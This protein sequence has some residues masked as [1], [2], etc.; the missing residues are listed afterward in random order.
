VRRR[1]ALVGVVAGVAALAAAAAIGIGWY[2]AG[3]IAKSALLVDLT[4]KT[5]DLVVGRVDGDTITLNVTD[6]TDIEHGDWRMPGLWGVAWNGG[7][8]EVNDIVSLNADSVVRSYA[9]V[10]AVIAAGDKVYLDASTFDGDPKTARGIDFR[11]VSFQAELGPLGAWMVDGERKTWA[12]MVHGKGAER[13]ESL[14]ALPIYVNAG[15]PAMV[16]QYRNDEGVARAPNG[17]Y[18]YGET[19]WRDLESAVRYAL[20]HG[21][22]DV[23]LVGFSMGGVISVSFLLHSDLAG[24]VRAA[25]LDAPVLNFADVIRYG[26]ERRDLPGWMTWLGMTAASLRFGFRWQDRDFLSRAGELKVPILLFHGTA[27]RLVNIRSSEA[28]AAARPDIVTFIKVPEA[29]HVRAWNVDPAGYEKAVND[30]LGRV[31]K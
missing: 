19:E 18:S 26:A 23:V 31:L 7:W 15:L 30:F 13:R 25:V 11:D 21:A 5:P 22:D 20:D 29:T 27:D 16:I 6:R 17:F 4:P 1:R 12:I 2:Y 8:G 9:P 3:E 28:L 10:R 14:R 24:K